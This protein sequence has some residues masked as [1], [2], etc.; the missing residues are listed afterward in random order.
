VRRCRA[1][2]GSGKKEATLSWCDKL[3]SVPSAGF[4]LDWH[5]ATGDEVLATFSPIL[6]PLVENER[7]DFNVQRADPF[8]VAINVN[9]GY[10]YGVEPSKIYVSFQHSVRAKSVSGGA[11]TMEMLSEAMPFTA[12]LDRVTDKLIK[13]TLIIPRHDVRKVTRFGVV[14]LTVVDDKEAPPGIARFIDY[15]GRPWGGL[16][17]NYSIQ[18]VSVV[19][20]EPQW[21]DRCV[22][23]LVKPENPDEL[24]T[25]SFDWHRT[26]TTGQSINQ[27]DLR[28]LVTR[29]CQDALQYFEDLAEGSRFDVD[30]DS[31]TA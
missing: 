14:S 8:S 4:M 12:L 19:G 11:P 16:L 23:T 13:A 22:H 20:N 18:I 10:H 26:F 6:D 31:P 30:S 5:F 9:D 25:L 7:P 3:A 29:G 24:T 2:F 27:H 1:G 28:R 15:V 17:N 21:I